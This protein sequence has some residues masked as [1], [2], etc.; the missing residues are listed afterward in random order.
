M[1]RRRLLMGTMSDRRALVRIAGSSTGAM[2][3]PPI[4]NSV[5]TYLGEF[6]AGE[7]AGCGAEAVGFDAE[8][9]EHGDVEIAERNALPLLAGIRLV[10]AVLEAATG[11]Q[12]RQIG[13]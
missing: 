7:G 5:Q 1:R 4:S 6:E 11:E 10:L 2:S 9:L 3:V 13:V 8:A 12:D